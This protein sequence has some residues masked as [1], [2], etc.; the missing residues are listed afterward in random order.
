[1]A[2]ATTDFAAA[3]EAVVDEAAG[4]VVDGA[5]D[6]VPAVFVPETVGDGSADAA[7]L[8]DA[9]APEAVPDT[10]VGVVGGV[11]LRV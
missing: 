3:A 2:G 11:P 5:V 9:V 4:G 7:L 1:M 6:G 10:G 8:P